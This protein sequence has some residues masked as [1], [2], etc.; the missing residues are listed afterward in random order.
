MPEATIN[1]HYSF[2]IDKSEVRRSWQLQMAAPALDA[3]DAEQSAECQFGGLFPRPW[4]RDMTWDRF[5]FE[6]T[7]AITLP[8]SYE[9]P[10]ICRR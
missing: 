4:M 8:A 1:E 3:V 6:K 5:F 2:L 9:A 7:S 10:G